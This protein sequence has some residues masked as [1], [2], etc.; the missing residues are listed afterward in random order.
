VE[1][2]TWV[3]SAVNNVWRIGD[4]FLRISFRGDRTRLHREA[5]LLD[6][7]PSAI[8][9]VE[10]VDADGLEWMLSKAVTGDNLATIANAIALDGYRAAIV[11]LAELLAVLPDWSPPAPVAAA[12]Q[13]E[14][15][16][17]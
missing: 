15:R 2:A 8:P 10:V 13:G 7:L 6:A 4:L 17:A 12:L 9:R 14:A 5:M 16:A 11:Q 1:S 3:D